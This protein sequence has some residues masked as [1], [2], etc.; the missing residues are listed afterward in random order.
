MKVE[1]EIV[2][3]LLHIWQK[4]EIDKQARARFM[5]AIVQETGLSQRDFCKTFNIPKSTLTGWLVYD[6]VTPEQYSVLK[7]VLSETDIANGLKSMKETGETA[8]NRLLN[9]RELN[10]G[11][12]KITP[13]SDFDTDVETCINI[14]KRHLHKVSGRIEININTFLELKNLVNRIEMK[15]K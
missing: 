11:V 3:E 14:L 7:D 2:E 15:L 9:M 4:P 1:K 6:K 12:I 10:K 13:T 5:R 8:Y